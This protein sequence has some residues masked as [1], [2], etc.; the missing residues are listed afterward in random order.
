MDA[1]YSDRLL[2]TVERSL[3]NGDAHNDPLATLHQV[4]GAVVRGDFDQFATLVCDDAEM[5]IR[6]FAPMNG[7]WRGRDEVVD[8]TRRN[9]AMITEQKPV[10]D[11]IVSHADS[12][13]V[14]LNETGV[15][16]TNQPYSLRAIQW[17]TFEAGRLKR[18]D[19]V[20]AEAVHPAQPPA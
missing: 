17:F 20:M 5:H 2:T 19:Q 10:I 8:A 6:G 14:L 16:N 15:L 1:Q 18:F 7:S 3:P 9:F 4:Y 11:K 13:I 12:V